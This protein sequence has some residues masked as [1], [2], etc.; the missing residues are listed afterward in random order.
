MSTLAGCAF[1]PLIQLTALYNFIIQ[2]TELKT[3]AK[4]WG[5]NVWLLQ[6]QINVSKGVEANTEKIW[7]TAELS[8]PER[9]PAPSVP[10]PHYY[11]RAHMSALHIKSLKLRQHLGKSVPYTLT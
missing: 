7:G 5:G 6:Q 11:I 9:G 4:G 8:V 1:I 3:S 2:L 10:K